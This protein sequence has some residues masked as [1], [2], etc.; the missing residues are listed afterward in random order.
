MEN[1]RHCL[2]YVI[3]LCYFCTKGD[4]RNYFYFL[5]AIES[6]TNK[7]GKCLFA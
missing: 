4:N 2:V 1:P 5:I 7:Y 6:A 3:C